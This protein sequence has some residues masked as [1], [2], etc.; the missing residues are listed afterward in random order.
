MRWWRSLLLGAGI[1][2][3]GCG[4]VWIGKI[5]GCPPPTE[6]MVD[7]LALMI[8]GDQFDAM[9]EWVGM[10]DRYCDGIDAM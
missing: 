6:A 8:Q 3:T 10:M 2:L 9:V 1:L 5:P 4:H 7:D